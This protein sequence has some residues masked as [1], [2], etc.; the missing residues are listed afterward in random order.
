[1]YCQIYTMILFINITKQSF[2]R[3]IPDYYKKSEI[4][5]IFSGH[6]FKKL[7]LMKPEMD[8]YKTNQENTKK[9]SKQ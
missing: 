5:P 6:R 8:V 4:I 3:I 2:Y 1:M 7:K 9:R